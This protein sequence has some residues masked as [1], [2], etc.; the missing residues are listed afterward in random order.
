[1]QRSGPRRSIAPGFKGVNQ[2]SAVKLITKVWTRMPWGLC[3][4]P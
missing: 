3:G 1:M 4:A 2:V